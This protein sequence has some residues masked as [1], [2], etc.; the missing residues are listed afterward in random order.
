M[1]IDYRKK[2]GLGKRRLRYYIFQ[3]EGLDNL[4]K[5]ALWWQNMYN[6]HRPHR[7][8]GDLTS[9]EKLRSLGYTT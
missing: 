9:Y 4:L 6:L 2:M 8:K 3:R 5:R 1:I 7:E